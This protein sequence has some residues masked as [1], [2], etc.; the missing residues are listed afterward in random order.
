MHFRT[1]LQFLRSV[2]WVVWSEFIKTLARQIGP[3][4]EALI[5][6]WIA[7]LAPA[8]GPPTASNV[9]GNLPQSTVTFW[10]KTFRKN[11]KHQTPAL[12]CSMRLPFPIHAGAN[13]VLFMYPTL[14]ANTSQAAE[15]T[16]GTGLTITPLQSSAVI[17]EYAD[18]A[19]VSSRALWTAIDNVPQNIAVEMAYRLGQSLHTVARLLIDTASSFDGSASVKLPASSTAVFTTLTLP[20]IRNEVQS[21][22]GR[23][24]HPPEGDTSFPGMIHPFALGD[25]LADPSN[26]SPIDIAKHTNEGFNKLDSF[27]STDITETIELPSSGVRFFQTALVTQTSNYNPGTG[28]VTGLTALRTY[29]IGEDGFFTYDLAAPG[30]IA[31]GQGEWQGIK[32]YI[33][34][35]A[36]K[37]AFDPSGL[38]QAWAAYKCHWT[39]SFGPDITARVRYIDAGSAVS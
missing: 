8:L 39:V 13:Y 16:V 19:T 26:N 14:P 5:Q 32:P 12:A 22:A 38:I 3:V 11:L 34:A 9:Q 1:S 25:V 21:M 33:E 31:I 17:G 23:A 20:V 2:I 24:I 18:Y 28:A 15:G 7:T 27:I 36:P 30:D 29:L 6:P 10:D 4:G 37:S 35:N